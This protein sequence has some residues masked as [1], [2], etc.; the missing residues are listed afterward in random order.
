MFGTRPEAIKMAPVVRALQQHDAIHPIVAVTAQ[1]REMLDQVLSLFEI[2]PDHDLDVMRPGQSLDSLFATVLCR[3]GGILQ[4]EAPAMLLVHGD[5]TT[6]AASALAGFHN[7]I[8]VG[9]VE[10]GLRTG[11]LRAPWP[12]EGNRRLVAPFADIHFCPTSRAAGN[13]L[14]E[15]IDPGRIHVTGNTV[16]DAVLDANARIAASPALQAALARQFDWLAPS[17]RLV[18]VTGHRRES[19]GHG[20]RQVCKALLALAERQDVQIVYPVHLNPAVR[21][22]VT[23]LLGTHPRI[24]LLPPQEYLPFI[25]LMRRASLV[26]TDSGGIQEEAPALGKPVLVTRDTTERTEALEQGTVKLVGTEVE[27]IVGSANEVLDRGFP[28]G[29]LQ[30]SP[31]GDGTAARRIAALVADF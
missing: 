25:E 5:T 30:S 11:D 29:G 13:L 28:A 22:P 19:F 10:A 14:A 16:I 15:G 23:A 17:S 9:H 27:R 2:R 4:Q 20:L 3:I 12:E 6:T 7:R 18:L 31:Y 21:G 8:P 26:I 1:H 24:H